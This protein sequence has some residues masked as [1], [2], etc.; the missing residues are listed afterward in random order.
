MDDQPDSVK[1]QKIQELYGEALELR[2]AERDSYLRQVCDGEE[3][4]YRQ[5]MRLIRAYEN[6]PD[7]LEVPFDFDSAPLELGGRRFG[8]YRLVRRLGSGGMGEVYLAERADGLFQMRVAIK[9]L[10]STGAGSS[11]GP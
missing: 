3:D 2:P 6:N 4:L 7:F 8:D 11:P 10:R 5:V 1:W 9:I